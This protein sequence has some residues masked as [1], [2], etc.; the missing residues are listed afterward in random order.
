MRFTLN[1]VKLENIFF[2][3]DT[4]FGHKM[5]INKRGFATAED[6]DE[7]L[8]KRWNSIVDPNS[9]IF[10]I[11]DISWY[12]PEK[13]SE[14]LGR[15]NGIKYLIYGNHDWQCDKPICKK[16]FKLM[17][18]RIELEV[19]DQETLMNNKNPKAPKMQ[20]VVL[21]HYPML[22][23]NKAYHGSLQL[24]GHVHGRNPGVG[25]SMDVG[26]DV[27]DLKPVSYAYIKETLK[28]K[29]NHEK[30]DVD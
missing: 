27:T 30:H 14:I 11:G 2:V 16:H 18:D 20:M 19:L 3:A 8:I 15:L 10:I 7:E 26:V 23:W 4:H 1:N 9:H 28:N 13:T 17:A 25:R 12:E 22:S 24:F 6:M 29:H 5:M 21:D